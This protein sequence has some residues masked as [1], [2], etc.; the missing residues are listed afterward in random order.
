MAQGTISID[1]EINSSLQI[2]D[3]LYYNCVK[4]TTMAGFTVIDTNILLGTV[5]NITNG[6]ITFRY[7]AGTLAQFPCDQMFISFKKDCSIN[8]SGLRGYYA[9]A[10]FTNNDFNNKNEIFS[11]NTQASL[12]SK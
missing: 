9:L 3:E 5:T 4:P 7:N 2:G 8:N 1:F 6:S 10:T 11:I 12:S